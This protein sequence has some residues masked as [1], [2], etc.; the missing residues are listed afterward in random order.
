KRCHECFLTRYPVNAATPLL[1]YS[2]ASAW[3]T[4]RGLLRGGAFV[5]TAAMAANNALAAPNAGRVTRLIPWVRIGQDNTVTL[6]ASQSEMAQGSTTPL[7]APLADELYLPL[8]K[9]TI[10]FAP[11]GPAY[12]D[13]VYNWMFTGNSQSTSSFFGMMRRMGAAAREM[14]IS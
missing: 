1:Q 2:D 8:E 11:F 14:L 10:E 3:M 12:R 4:R 7:A 9:V 13:P 6:I 5:L